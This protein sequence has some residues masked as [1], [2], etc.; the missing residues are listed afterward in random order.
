MVKFNFSI[1]GNYGF[2]LFYYLRN[3]KRAIINW[4]R[5]EAHIRE[6]FASRSGEECLINVRNYYIGNPDRVDLRSTRETQARKE[7]QNSLTMANFQPYLIQKQGQKEAGVD[8]RLAIEAVK[9]MSDPGVK[10]FVLCSGDGDFCTLLDELHDA[11]IKVMLILGSVPE[12]ATDLKATYNSAVLESMADFKIDLFSFVKKFPDMFDYYGPQPSNHFS[13]TQQLPHNSIVSAT[14][15][16]HR[17]EGLDLSTGELLMRGS[18]ADME[19][20]MQTPYNNIMTTAAQ[21]GYNAPSNNAAFMTNVVH[22][23]NNAQSQTPI[24]SNTE[25]NTQ[26]PL[27]TPGSTKSDTTE[28][29]QTLQNAPTKTPVAEAVSEQSATNSPQ[30]LQNPAEPVKRKR[31]RPRKNPLPDTT[32]ANL[33]TQEV[34]QKISAQEKDARSVTSTSIKEENDTAS[35]TQAT[36]SNDNVALTKN[37]TSTAQDATIKEEK[38]PPLTTTVAAD[39]LRYLMEKRH[40][41]KGVHVDYIFLSDLG[42]AISEA[43]YEMPKSGLK[44][45]LQNFPDMFTIGTNMRTGHPTV[46]FTQKPNPQRRV[47]YRRTPRVL[48]GSSNRMPPHSILQGRPTPI[49]N[50]GRE[51]LPI[52]NSGENG[53]D[54][55]I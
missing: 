34:D 54:A 17:I 21:K 19:R 55:L 5:L 29:T 1:D 9:H 53:F 15:P 39:Q 41:E 45:Y 52:G 26:K 10:Y 32:Q 4:R 36:L 7:Y 27:A 24:T 25:S 50:G 49:G 51:I 2:H 11:G 44:T 46:S 40:D 18:K 14:N 48:R 47:P 30:S 28:S 33:F 37:Q 42:I 23:Y 16:I 22:D 43:G 6:F 12:G 38:K 3:E 8:I 31:G 20:L 13:N 35:N